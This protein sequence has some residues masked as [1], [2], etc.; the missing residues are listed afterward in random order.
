[1]L[2]VESG[3]RIK[4]LVKFKFKIFINV[5]WFIFMLKNWLFLWV[6]CI[7][8]MV[9]L[10]FSDV[11]MN[12]FVRWLNKFW[13]SDVINMVVI[14]IGCNIFLVVIW[15]VVFWLEFGRKWFF[16]RYCVMWFLLILWMVLKFVLL[17]KYCNCIFIWWLVWWKCVLCICFMWFYIEL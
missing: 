1:M 16:M 3:V 15:D 5:W 2:K 7:I 4:W 13:Y 6:S 8:V 9:L 12:F 10:D 11:C 14:F 17:W